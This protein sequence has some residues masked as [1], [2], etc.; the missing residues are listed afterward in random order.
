MALSY[1]IHNEFRFLPAFL[2]EGD[3]IIYTIYI[4]INVVIR[5]II[6]TKFRH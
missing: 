5:I 4:R 3:I 1:K 2:G 6:N